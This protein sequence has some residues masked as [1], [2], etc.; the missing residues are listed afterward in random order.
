MEIAKQLLL[1]AKLLVAT[2]HHL[3]PEDV[4]RINGTYINDT[5]HFTATIS[6]GDSRQINNESRNDFAKKGIP[7]Q[8]VIQVLNSLQSIFK[9]AVLKNS[10][11]GQK[12]NDAYDIKYYTNTYN[13][14]KITFQVHFPKEGKNRQP[15]AHIKIYRLYIEKETSTPQDGQ[16]IQ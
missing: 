4:I 11:Q 2:P 3:K 14:Y 8:I 7:E 16:K 5:D 6:S 10:K 13:G 15:N 9:N 1:L 12:T